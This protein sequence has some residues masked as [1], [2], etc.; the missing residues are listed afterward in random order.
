M[1][2]DYLIPY[3]PVGT[4]RH[5]KRVEL[6]PEIFMEKY[7]F[8]VPG[9]ER[10]APAE[11]LLFSYRGIVKRVEAAWSDGRRVTLSFGS[12]NYKVRLWKQPV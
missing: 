8:Y 6:A 5:W 2:R 11:A 4:R 10:P 7:A 3:R 12:R 1:S 9:A